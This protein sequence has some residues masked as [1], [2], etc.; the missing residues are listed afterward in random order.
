[1]CI[2]AAL[3]VG[4]FFLLD[5]LDGETWDPA[6]E[7][8]AG[9]VAER[10][11]AEF[12]RPV[13]VDGLAPGEYGGRLAAIFAA[14]DPGSGIDGA[15]V[16]RAFGLLE[17]EY[18]AGAVGAYLAGSRL[19]VFDPGTGRIAVDTAAMAE[20]RDEA[21][22]AALDIAL[23]DQLRRWSD[24][25]VG[26]SP[27]E[28]LGRRGIVEGDARLLV[29]A[30]TT[31]APGAA[32]RPGT[33]LPGDRPPGVPDGVI[34]QAAVGVEVG[35]WAVS[36]IGGVPAFDAALAAP[37]RNDIALWDPR[38]SVLRGADEQ[39]QRGSGATSELG[40][41][42][43]FLVLAG[44][45]APAEAWTAVQTWTGDE[46]RF[47]IRGGR[48]CVVS[49]ITTRDELSGFVLLDA[50]TRWAAA[51]P[52]AANGRVEVGA[53]S[54]SIVVDVCD[55]GPEASTRSRSSAPTELA[56]FAVATWA[57]TGTALAESDPVTARCV[58]DRTTNDGS[59]A[60]LADRIIG[61][62]AEQRRRV[63][64]DHD[65]TPFVSACTASTG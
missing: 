21:L 1:M 11:S 46:Q 5:A 45:L 60:R 28:R 6:I 16:A 29:D 12:A 54:S 25:F 51:G 24:G 15:G 55:P 44:R 7:A 49:T 38:V 61:V 4:A 48:T 13:G 10:R 14:P 62:D 17:G 40:L 2:L 8:L 58:V 9:E 63:L 31:G 18:D 23:A 34:L 39:V 35:S 30:R 26:A 41:G 20:R 42:H 65:V 3:A 59:I 57:V 37:V 64:D 32:G 36:T 43:W 27:A 22:V 50:L 52:A 19:A 47:V 53:T 33:L 56:A